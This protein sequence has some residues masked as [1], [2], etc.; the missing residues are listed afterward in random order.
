MSRTLLRFC[1]MNFN[2]PCLSL[3][4]TKR[5]RQKALLQPP[6]SFFTTGRY[7]KKAFDKALETS[8]GGIKVFE[9]LLLKGKHKVYS[10]SLFVFLSF[11]I[12]PSTST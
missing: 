1:S 3:L 2:S 7:D 5:V 6:A 12:P 9:S 11:R 8:M 10:T 4:S